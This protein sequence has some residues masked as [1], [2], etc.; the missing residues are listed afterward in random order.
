MS[1][2]TRRS[3]FSLRFRGGCRQQASRMR[4]LGPLNRRLGLELLE[5][6]RLLALVTVSNVFD[7]VNGNTTSITS[8][9]ATPGGDGISLREAIQAANA[10]AG[11]DEVRFAAALSGATISLGGTELAI[12]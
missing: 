1:R 2:Q 7:V 9:I 6:R 12:S 5:D 3:A 8:L 10:T 4:S 11:A